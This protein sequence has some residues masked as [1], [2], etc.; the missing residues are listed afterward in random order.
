VA[1]RDTVMCYI[2][3]SALNP[4][5]AVF[6]DGPDDTTL[7]IGGAVFVVLIMIGILTWAER[8]KFKGGRSCL[9]FCPCSSI[10]PVHFNPDAEYTER[11]R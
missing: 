8:K 9:N 4:E 5:M 11:L 6:P 10:P 3:D 7:V 2:N 1:I